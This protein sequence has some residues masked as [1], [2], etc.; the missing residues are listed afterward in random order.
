MSSHSEVPPIRYPVYEISEVVIAC[1]TVESCL[2]RE[3]TEILPVPRNGRMAIH[4]MQGRIITAICILCNCRV[5]DAARVFDINV[6]T[7]HNRRRWWRNR[8]SQAVQAE[9]IQRVRQALQE[10]T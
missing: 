5:A 2:A 8:C 1:S 7:A 3:T 10:R 6:T 9:Y 4:Q